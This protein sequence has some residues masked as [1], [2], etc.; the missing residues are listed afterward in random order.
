MRQGYTREAYLDLVQ[1]IWRLVQD[2]GFSSDF[3]CCFCGETEEEHAKTLSLIKTV[4]YDMAH[5][6]CI[7]HEIKK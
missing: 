7:Q 1:K 4:G 3:I 5:M 6:F 2:V